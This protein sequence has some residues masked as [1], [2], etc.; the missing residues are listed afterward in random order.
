MR[1]LQAPFHYAPPIPFLKRLLVRLSSRHDLMRGA[2]NTH[3]PSEALLCSTVLQGLPTVQQTSSNRSLGQHTAARCAGRIQLRATVAANIGRPKQLHELHHQYAS[4][5]TERRCSSD[6]T[7]EH[8]IDARLKTGAR[9]SM[10][11]FEWSKHAGN[12]PARVKLRAQPTRHVLAIIPGR[13][14]HLCL[15][16]C[17]LLFVFRRHSKAV[18]DDHQLSGCSTVATGHSIQCATG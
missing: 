5:G 18:Q 6:A 16:V 10:G 8:S 13:H 1:L 15:P 7:G 12:L 4:A 14:I 3:R 17:R 2:R 9:A 11:R